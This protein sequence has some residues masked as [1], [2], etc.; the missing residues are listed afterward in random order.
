MCRRR[1]LGCVFR[2]GREV[3]ITTTMQEVWNKRKAA[4]EEWLCNRRERRYQGWTSTQSPAAH[5]F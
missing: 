3:E 2:P 1:L 5:V 4:K